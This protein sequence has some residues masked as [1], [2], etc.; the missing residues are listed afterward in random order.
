MG[1]KEPAFF[2][3]FFTAKV[4]ARITQRE[5]GAIF[6]PKRPFKGKPGNAIGVCYYIK[7]LVSY[8]GERYLK[9]L[10][11]SKSVP[12]ENIWALKVLSVC[13]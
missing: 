4:S 6:L 10:R 9:V 5:S 11:Q 1:M 3:F 7:S 12:N 2:F 8:W 13:H